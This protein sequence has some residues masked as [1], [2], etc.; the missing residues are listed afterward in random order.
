MSEIT[1]VDFWMLTIVF[2]ML[3]FLAVDL[4]LNK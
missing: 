1:D 2:L 3:L 4:I